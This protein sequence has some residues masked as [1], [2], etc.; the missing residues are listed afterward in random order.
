MLASR[1]QCFCHSWWFGGGEFT[2]YLDE[3][4]HRLAISRHHVLCSHVTSIFMCSDFVVI[5]ETVIITVA[6]SLHT[7]LPIVLMKCIS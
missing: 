5:G 7:K 1:G 4:P 2:A 6:M 3:T